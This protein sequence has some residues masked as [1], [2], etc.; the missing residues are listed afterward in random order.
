LEQGLALSHLTLRRRHRLQL[1]S[2]LDA[3][4]A[5][6][7]CSSEA[8]DFGVCNDCCGGTELVPWLVTSKAV[9]ITDHAKIKL[10]EKV[11]RTVLKNGFSSTSGRS[12]EH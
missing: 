11:E 4:A 7:L 6:W 1:A 3:P 5:A 2:F 9:S 10:A 8:D 12:C